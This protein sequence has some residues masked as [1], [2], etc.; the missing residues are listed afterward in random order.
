MDLLTRA[1]LDLLAGPDEP[2]THLSL[3]LPTHRLGSEDRTDPL[4]WKNLLTSTES[5]LSDQGMRQ[6]SAI[7]RTPF[8]CMFMRAGGR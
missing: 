5:A 1:D 8:G 2:G 3:F 6:M 4:R 7:L